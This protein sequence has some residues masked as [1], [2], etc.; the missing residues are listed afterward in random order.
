MIHV[1][2]FYCLL[3]RQQMGRDPIVWLPMKAKFN[4]VNDNVSVVKRYYAEA[5]SWR[6]TQL[7][8]LAHGDL[9]AQ[10]RRNRWRAVGDTV[11]N[12]T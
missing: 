7:R 8:D 1:Q 5:C 9:G 11:S 6:G 3:G 2:P 10:L 12:L 4:Q